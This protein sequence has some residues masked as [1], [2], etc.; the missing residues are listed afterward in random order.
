MGM[1]SFT[2][3]VRDKVLHS[4][5][6]SNRVPFL[7]VG[8]GISQR[9]MGSENWE[10]LL[11]WVCESV[12][13]PMR[14]FYIYR[15]QAQTTITSDNELYPRIAHLMEPDF[16]EATQDTRFHEWVD[17]HSQEL[18]R[19]TIA[20]KIYIADHL[21]DREPDRLIDELDALRRASN[22]V[23]GV[24]TTNY[25]T[26]MED[27][28]PDYDCY[29]RQEDLLF[30]S[31][32]G[33]GEIYKIHGSAT[34]PRSMILDTHDYAS[35]MEHK[36]YMMAKIM[37]LLGEYPVI[38]LGYSLSDPDVQS[39]I[40]T[41][42]ACAGTE[43]AQKMA[44]RFIFVSYNT[45][46]H[47]IE[48][49]RSFNVG[50]SFISMSAIHTDDFTPIYEAIASMNQTFP[51]K[52]LN[53]LTRQIFK[54]ALSTHSDSASH[55]IFEGLEGAQTLP[56]DPKI[57]I[58]LG[59]RDYGKPIKTIEMYEDV[60]FDNKGFN[61]RLIIGDY[62][63]NALKNNTGGL[64]MFKYL[65]EQPDIALEDS[66]AVEI[67]KRTSV[68][69][70][71]S[72]TERKKRNRIRK[73]IQDHSVQGVIESCG[74]DTAYRKMTCLN[75]EEFDAQAL[76]EYLR[77]M[78]AK[79]TVCRPNGRE[80]R[81]LEDPEFRKCIRIYDFLKYQPIFAQKKLTPTVDANS[82]PRRQSEGHLASQ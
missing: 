35:F 6:E 60:L 1:E 54:E 5:E 66:L 28:F 67:E 41:L 20:M 25:D 21:T 24:I 64:P 8:S 10:E 30:S 71:L 55:V 43:R 53:Q 38:F 70:Y 12:G 73:T 63:G 34:D 9:Y 78:A 72:P 47:S 79:K 59:E 16:L 51:P 7:F 40:T 45:T 81:L 3:D 22:H 68:N 69:A 56:S 52:A 74:H 23:A 2:R 13:A 80:I 48:N 11:K 42:A 49:A 4:L 27:I 82:T 58:G 32:T 15:Q 29:I 31:L 77:T 39:I 37:T 17:R 44:D 19:G 65:A 33:V 50:D 26:L 62:L 18:E 75:Q 76:G 14:P 61:A 46:N 36:D 57:V